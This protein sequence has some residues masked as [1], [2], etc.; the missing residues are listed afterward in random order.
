MKK[1]FRI[2]L[3]VLAGLLLVILAAF[4]AL[5]SPKVQ[6]WA[7]KKAVDM[8][9]EKTDADIDFNMVSLRPFEA[10]TLDDVSIID[11]NPQVDG[12]DT[13]AFIGSLNVK[14]TPWGLLTGDGAY[15]SS[16]R[17][18]DATVQ[19]VTEAD[20]LSPTGSRMNLL[21]IFRLP[22]SEQKD[23]LPTWGN[24]LNARSLVLRNV[25]VRMSNPVLLESMEA[26]GAQKGGKINFAD[27]DATVNYLGARNIK[28]A[29]SKVV[30][31]LDTLSAY[32]KSGF[33]LHGASA[34][35]VNVAM[36]RIRLDNLHLKDDFSDI[37]LKTLQLDGS[38]KGYSDF[39]EKILIT[40]DIRTESLVSMKTVAFFG[41]LE[42]SM[43]FRGTVKGKVKGYVNDLKLTDMDAKDQDH[44]FSARVNGRIM[45]VTDIQNSSLD[46]NLQEAKF[47]LKGLE[48]FLR[49]WA[50]DL[51]LDL[52]NFG[53]GELFS[54][55]GTAK[56]PLNR[57]GVN[58]TLSSRLGIAKA[59]ITVRN[60]VDEKR[61]IIID[62]GLRT[63]DLN[64]GKIAGIDA[65]GPV[66]LGTSLSASLPKGGDGISVRIDSLK[67]DRL[68]ALGYDYTNLSAV[69]N[70]AEDAFDGRIIAADPNLNFLFQGKFNLSKKTKN[71]VYR[72][73][74]SLG[75]ADLHALKIDKRPN[76]KISFQAYS[77][78]LMTES[79]DILGDV[80][81]SGLTLESATGTHHLGDLTAKAHSNDDVSRINISSSFLEG[82]YYGDKGPFD[83]INHLRS[84]TLDRELNALSTEPAPE[85]D[86]S[87]YSLDLKVK[88]AHDFLDFFAPGAYAANPTEVK[89]GI[90]ENGT[91]RG[92]INSDRLALGEKYIRNL[93]LD[94]TNDKNVLRADLTSSAIQIASGVKLLGSRLSLFANDN[95]LGVGYSFDNT[96]EG[97]SKA[98]LYLSA[99]LDRDEEG[100]A[101]VARALPSNLYYRGSGW[102]ISSGDILF[103]GGDISVDALRAR[104]DTELLEVDG[105]FSSRKADTLKVSMEKFDVGIVS[106]FIGNILPI[107]GYA[108]GNAVIISP[109]N[110]IPG[111]EAA[112]V[113]DSTRVSGQ[114]I[115][116][117]SLASNWDEPAKRFN[118]DARTLLDG[119]NTLNIGGYFVPEGQTLSA[120]ALL[121]GLDLACISPILSTVFSTFD[122]KLGGAVTVNGPVSKLKIGSRD[123]KLSDG[124]I[125]LD[126]T[127]A[128]YDVE[129]DLALTQDALSLTELRLKDN[130]GGKATV[131]GDILLNGFQDLGTDLRINM[132]KLKALDLKRGENP[133]L[134]GSLPVSGNLTV[135]G[136]LSR[137][138]VNIDAATSGPG[139]LHLP[140]GGAS[141]EVQRKMLVFTEPPDKLQQDP[142]ELM[143]A[144][145]AK[146]AS[147]SSNLIINLSA[148]ATPDAT[149]YIDLG[150]NT[151]NARGSGNI[152]LN[153]ETAQNSFGLS[154]DYTLQEGS[155][156]FS[157]M[158]L[159][160]RD[161]TIQ[162]GS[163]V[164]FNGPVNE[165]DLN[166]KGLYTTKASL[167]NLMTVT[168]TES[169]SGSSRRTV[170]CGIDI[171]GKLRN[172]EL[173]FSIDV[174]DL[175]P[176]TKIAIDNALSTEDKVQKQFVYLL[177]ASSFLPDEDSGV[178]TTGSEM[179]YSNVSSIMSG[180]INNIFEKLNIPLDLGLN[181]KAQDG[182]NLFDVAVSTQLFNNRVIVNGAVGNKQLVGSTTSEITGDIDV[183]IKLGKSGNL[184]TT[185]FS[186][187][188]DQFS[189]YL[190]N[191]QRNGVGMTYQKE[192]Y[193]IS[194]LFNEMFLTRQEREERARRQLLNTAIPQSYM[195]IDSTGK[196]KPIEEKNE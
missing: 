45:N 67:I 33:V 17:L 18:D 193:S 49:S 109:G 60:T 129:G 127:R 5:Q 70:Y 117:L 119:K 140:I 83:F 35:K 91:I 66:T 176:S 72:F 125:A 123:L 120:E 21:R 73:Y 145:N 162:D 41:P 44:N 59:D 131:K 158:N 75:Y 92:S 55:A 93:D 61:P 170:N 164:R 179:L 81:V 56:G 115:G 26:Q 188:A 128:L 13:I 174:P 175:N 161:F 25:R 22:Y 153:I 62:G 10:V 14:F 134:Y 58:G 28:V 98:E 99:D 159:V 79:H 65:I 9:R 124:H 149:V 27:I 132:E 97:E 144:S 111:V 82:S 147:S 116:T 187:S 50:P 7:G 71:K 19:L 108:S 121:N 16:L 39:V 181:Y 31:A 133:T 54:F 142:Y 189:S 30:L 126:F 183:E 110:P 84:L 87:T 177:I 171:T 68:N 166:V 24:I 173:R 42:E 57:L 34:G 86:G 167:D 105:G 156:R 190:D 141:G 32:E 191:S 172:P 90:D 101:V 3:K 194:Q 106:N 122:G 20:S 43:D 8:L 118:L 48:G 89:L 150:E 195:Q 178:T 6:T 2:F 100:L 47:T 102:G 196:P 80:N 148:H 1:F 136:P 185:L 46:I 182:R 107:E 29:D 15:V 112:I 184:R 96:E 139:D 74:A 63:R 95:H 40:G 85:W 12:A 64:V 103:K 165:T 154:G 69:G 113:C 51:S 163:S 94:L 151:L 53:K 137:I 180:Q 104:D 186:H 192:F 37:R 38:I 52:D 143:M 36:D 76:S 138:V 146:Q 4:A 160:S 169:S 157:A 78:F 77:N 130:A 168:E 135:K 155:F 88:D 11:R 152:G 114:R 23:E